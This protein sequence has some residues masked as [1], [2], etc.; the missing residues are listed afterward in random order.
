MRSERNLIQ[1]SFSK[2]LSGIGVD[3]IFVIV[4]SYENVAKEL[5]KDTS[6]PYILAATMKNAVRSTFVV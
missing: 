4:Q 6:V 5:P 3:D 2:N 1:N